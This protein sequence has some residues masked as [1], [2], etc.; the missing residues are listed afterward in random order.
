VVA[1]IGILAAIALPLYA[2]MQRRARVARAEADVHA[3]VSAVSIYTVH[4]GSLP[5]G[6]A[7]L[8][9]PVLNPQGLSAGPFMP[10]T[11]QAPA[12]WSAYAYASATTGL[13][14]ISTSGDG[15]TVIR[16]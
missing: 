14:L 6:L 7:D 15:T 12:G 3:L 16:P 11:P 2:S 5:A 1:V 9:A 8:N 10:S 4:V 13:F